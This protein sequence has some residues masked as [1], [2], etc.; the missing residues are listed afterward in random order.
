VGG[1]IVDDDMDLALR[2]GGD[3]PVNEIEELDAPACLVVAADDL[4][5]ATLSAAN[6]VVVQ[7]R[8]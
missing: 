1:Q 3:S 2:I 7:C 4:A 8:L 6:G 5:T